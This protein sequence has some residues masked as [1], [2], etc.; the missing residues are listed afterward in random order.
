MQ[1]AR[2]MAGTCLA[3]A[4]A[5]ASAHGMVSVTSH[6]AKGNGATDD[7]PAIQA[8]IAATQGRGT[9]F[10]PFV[11]KGI[12]ELATATDAEAVLRITAPIKIACEPGVWLRPSASITGAQSIL[13][14]VGTSLGSAPDAPVYPQAP[15]VVD[16]CN[17]GDPTSVVRHGNHGIV[18]D[19]STMAP[20]HYQLFKRPIITNV[21]I[22]AANLG[23]NSCLQA[24]PTGCAIFA[25]NAP[26]NSTGGFVWATIEKSTLSGGVHLKLSGDSISLRDVVLPPNPLAPNASNLGVY[27]SLIAG[28]GNLLLDKVSCQVLSGCVVLDNTE[29]ATLR[30]VTFEMLPFPNTNPR[31]T[32]IEIGV[33]AVVPSGYVGA[34]HILGGSIVSSD[35]TN[36]PYL[37]SYGKAIG[38]FIDSV[39]LGHNCP[40][41]PHA[42]VHLG[43]DSRDIG[44]GAGIWWQNLSVTITDP[45]KKYDDLGTGNFRVHRVPA[46]E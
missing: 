32:M 8:A 2:Y 7:R 34:V 35:C 1:I 43:L 19:T 45:A 31:N 30:D 41:Y 23:R 27:A 24:A 25:L 44:I 46:T 36:K 6:G 11:G 17:I 22:T 12:Y 18:F 26:T 10:F 29:S 33:S 42:L 5:S 37:I 4:L 15:T 40:S 3:L 20:P 14:F 9:L 38:G 28:A 13:Y 16:G 21:T 39:R